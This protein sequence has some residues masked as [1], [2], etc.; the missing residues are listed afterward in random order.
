MAGNGL[1][2][3]RCPDLRPGRRFVCKPSFKVDDYRYVVQDSIRGI[4]VGEL[5]FS[6]LL[7]SALGAVMDIGISISTTVFEI[8][9]QKPELNRKEL[10]CSGLNVG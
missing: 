1:K 6:G 5:L 10:F 4:R 3:N 8:H 7:I 9:D 2:E